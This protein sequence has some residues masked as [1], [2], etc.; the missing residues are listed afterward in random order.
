MNVYTVC[1]DIHTGTKYQ[2]S[3][4]IANTRGCNYFTLWYC[5]VVNHSEDLNATYSKWSL[6]SNGLMYTQPLNS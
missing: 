6:G 3:V 2:L 1:L 4:Q 5:I